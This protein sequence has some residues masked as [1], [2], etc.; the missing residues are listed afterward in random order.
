MKK[1]ILLAGVLLC[2]VA[3]TQAQVKVVDSSARKAPTWYEGARQDYIIVTSVDSDMERAKTNALDDVRKHII[4]SV[5]QNVTSSSQGN[6]SQTSVDGQI[7]S[8]LDEYKSSMS[9]QA[10]SVPYLKGI[11]ASRIEE[12]YWEKRQDR[13]TGAVTYVYS[14]LY[15]FPSVELKSLVAEF[16][17]RDKQMMAEY[18]RLASEIHS[19]GSVE[20]IDKAVADLNPLIAYFFDEVRKNQARTLQN[21]Y[22][23]LYDRITFETVSNELGEYRFRLM[24]EGRP[25]A[26]SQR[27]TLKADCATKLAAQP[28]GDVITVTYDYDGCAWDEE[29]GVTVTMRLNNKNVA[30]KFHYTVKKNAVEVYPE[31]TVYLTASDKGDGVVTNIEI[32]MTIHSDLGGPYT[33]KNVTLEVPGLSEPLFLDYLDMTFD[34][35]TSTLN[36]TWVRG[37]EIIRKQSYRL[38]M[39]RG[40]M[41]VE[42]RGATKRVDFALPFKAN[43]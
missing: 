1:L 33:V 29:N 19:V 3:V 11:S 42:I 37:T 8:F 34:A 26:T 13:S 28:H 5:A 27:M 38:N 23:A 40:H 4:E 6:I 22:R 21:N 12:F 25:I 35:T 30:H 32:R 15:P 9:T 20:Q 7:T 10:A 18:E 31:K 2:T 36:V 43:W 14:I 17:K 16:Q 39:L 41:E 24:L